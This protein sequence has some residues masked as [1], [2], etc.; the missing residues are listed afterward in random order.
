MK[1]LQEWAAHGFGMG[2]SLFDVG[3][4]ICTNTSSP[5][6]LS[7]ITMPSICDRCFNLFPTKASHLDVAWVSLQSGDH[8]SG[9]FKLSHL[10]VI[11]V[12]FKNH[13][14]LMYLANVKST[15][16]SKAFTFRFHRCSISTPLHPFVS[17]QRGE[18]KHLLIKIIYGLSS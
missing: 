5:K 8:F 13:C 6:A 16:F 2:P 18:S 11:G 12:S 4:P 7:F 15:L 9:N 3:A 1:A 14:T 10:D 17:C